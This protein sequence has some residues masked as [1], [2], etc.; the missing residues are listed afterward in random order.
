MG[1]F[2][3]MREPCDLR[4]EVECNGG[5]RKHPTEGVCEILVSWLA[6]LLEGSRSL[7]RKSMTRGVLLGEFIS[8]SFLFLLSLFTMS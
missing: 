2:V 6:V 5:N 1:A 8:G 7:K 3:I 4:A